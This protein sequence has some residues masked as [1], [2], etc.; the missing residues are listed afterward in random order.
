MCGT[1]VAIIGSALVGAAS[2]KYQSDKQEAAMNKQLEESRKAAQEQR[3]Q[4]EAETAL[5]NK[6]FEEQ[7]AADQARFD[8]Q[9]AAAL[10]LEK[11]REL[12]LA[13]LE[14][15]PI[16]MRNDAQ[17]TRTKGG[18]MLGNMKVKKKAEGYTSVGGVGGGTGVNV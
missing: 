11:K 16:M 4:Y 3:R 8:S 1:A 12:E 18:S 6:Q 5:M 17:K 10:E 7:K 14:A 2:S 13:K 9:Q 15:V